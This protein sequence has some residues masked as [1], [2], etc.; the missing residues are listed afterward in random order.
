MM[1]TILMLLLAFGVG[2]GWAQTNSP[3]LKMDS[4]N[5]MVIQAKTA[6]YD[7]NTHET[8]FIGDVRVNDPKIKLQCERLAVILPQKSEHLSHLLAE[9]NVVIDM[10]DDGQ[11]RHLTAHKATYEYS[12]VNAVTNETVVFTGLPDQKPLVTMPDG[13]VMSSEPIIWD[14]VANRIKFSEFH[15]IMQS[16]TDTNSRSPLKLN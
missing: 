11:T 8:I 10:I 9:T 12:V 14:R 1:K 16:L 2:V 7:N 5:K 6:Y 3:A 15:G 4:T 13:S